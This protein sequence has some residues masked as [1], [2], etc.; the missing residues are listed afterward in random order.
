MWRGLPRPRA[1]AREP[2]ARRLFDLIDHQLPARRVTLLRHFIE[3]DNDSFAPC[4]SFL[5]QCIGDPFRDL[6]LLIGGTALQHRDLDYRHGTTPR[7]LAF[8]LLRP[9]LPAGV[10]PHL[11][12]P[13]RRRYCA[14]SYPAKKKLSSKR[15]VSSASEP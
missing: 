5:H 1:I 8:V 2:R 14:S 9:Q 3:C 13:G 12:P 6:A 7:V 11:G 4:S 15:A 10:H